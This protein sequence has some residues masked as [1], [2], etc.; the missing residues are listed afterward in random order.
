MEKVEGCSQNEVPGDVSH[1]E[2]HLCVVAVL[3][4]AVQSSQI[5]CPFG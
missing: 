4:V 2:R 3:T 5:L 1:W